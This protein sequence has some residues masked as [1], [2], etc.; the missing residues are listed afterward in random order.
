MRTD[1]ETQQTIIA[2][3]GELHLEIILDRLRR[4]FKVEA[5][6][7]KPQVAYKEAITK[8]VEKQGKF[9]RQLGR[10]RPV[11]RRKVSAW[12]QQGARDRFRIRLED[13][14]RQSA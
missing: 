11:Q 10:Q 3:M 6:V 5:N 2:H 4:E 8:T 7:G 9:V 12:S 14:R 1:E 13:R